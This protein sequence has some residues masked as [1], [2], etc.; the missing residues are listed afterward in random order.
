MNILE[1]FDE[2]IRNVFVILEIFD[3]EVDIIDFR[4]EMML[5]ELIENHEFVLTI[6]DEFE[7]YVKIVE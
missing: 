3:N 2:I 4:I 7:L 1:Q 6:V 5:A